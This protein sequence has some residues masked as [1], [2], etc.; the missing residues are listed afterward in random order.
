M[1]KIR[2]FLTVMVII[3]L[4]T[5]CKQKNS[6]QQSSV[7]SEN[8]TE[9][10]SEDSETE[11]DT[12]VNT[13]MGF[14]KFESKTPDGQLQL[15]IDE[16]LWIRG[17]DAK[18]LKKYGYDPEEVFEDF[19]LHNEVVEWKQITTNPETTYRIIMYESN[20]DDVVVKNIDVDMEKFDLYLFDNNYG[21]LVKITKSPSGAIQSI[22]E[23]YMP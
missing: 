20:A 18:T 5:G 4:I 13:I 16:V 10:V 19:I 22:N 14:I 6:Q 23:H 9:I 8:D 12:D 2:L 1:Q 15:I 11:V 3:S 21:V 17:D 7:A